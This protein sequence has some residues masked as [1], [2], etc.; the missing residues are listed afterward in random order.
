LVESAIFFAIGFLVA[1]LL[2]LM[3]VPAVS[4][5]ATRLAN[6]RARLQAPLSE[7]Q[8]RAERDAL[9]GEHAI[10]IARVERRLREL[11]EKSGRGLVELGRRAA[12][13][14]HLGEVSA[15]RA[16]EIAR[17][18]TEIAGLENETRDLATQLS[19]SLVAL[20]DFERQRDT[21]QEQL[22]RAHEQIGELETGAHDSRGEVAG[23]QTR[24]SSL[25]VEL[26]GA[27]R[28]VVSHAQ[29][30]AALEG[31]LGAAR[32]RAST[33]EG[34]IR[35]R[36]AET[37][38]LRRRLSEVEPLLARAEAR[39]EREAKLAL[40]ERGDSSREAESP[41]ARLV[42]TP[43]PAPAIGRVD[44]NLRQAILRLGRG[45]DVEDEATAGQIVNFTR[46]ESTGVPCASAEESPE[47]R[48]G[49]TSLSRPRIL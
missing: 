28:R 11:E 7:T 44:H 43:A 42:E 5:R 22:V 19:A 30:V 15:R 45:G 4:R 6:A 16:D 1:A 24:L 21:V 10:E 31:E 8:A 35:D 36:A 37:G 23:L 14:V 18:R 46:R 13:I 17:Q 20:H 33:L 26:A 40:A 2:A 12:E 9:R 48:E 29:A 38:M 41:R 27:R 34:D 3:A 49:Q 32:T 47:P 25:E 39:L